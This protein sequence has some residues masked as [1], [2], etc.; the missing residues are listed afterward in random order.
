MNPGVS[1]C[2][3][4]P[5]HFQFGLFGL[6]IWMNGDSQI[7]GPDQVNLFQGLIY[8]VF[9]QHLPTQLCSDIYFPMS[10]TCLNVW[11]NFSLPVCRSS[12][13]GSFSSTLS[14]MWVNMF[15]SWSA[16]LWTLL[17]AAELLHLHD[18]LLLPSLAELHYHPDITFQPGQWYIHRGSRRIFH[19]CNCNPVPKIIKKK[20]KREKNKK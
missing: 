19:N 18:Q 6:Q 14:K 8:N 11:A 15:L 4:W 7:S 10:C 13:L 9:P 2:C 16:L 20:K 17:T 1:G 12:R 3:Y 5:V